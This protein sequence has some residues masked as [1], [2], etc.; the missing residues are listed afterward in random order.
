VTDPEQLRR[1][2]DADTAAWNSGSPQ[3]VAEF[4]APDGRIV[5]NRGTP[6]EG[7]AGV[8]EMAAGFYADVPDLALVCCASR[9]GR[10]GTWG[11]T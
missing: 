10:S 5:I 3:A 2:A 1:V 9:A 8:A 6:W 7:R 11:R 4:F